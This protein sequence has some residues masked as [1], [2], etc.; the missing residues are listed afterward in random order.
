MALHFETNRL[1]L[2]QFCNKDTLALENV[3][4]DAEVMR[5]GAGVQ[6]VDWISRWIVKQQQ[7]YN[8]MPGL[9]LMAVVENSSGI[10]CG[11][12]GLTHFPDI[13]GQPEI[14]VGY[15]LAQQYWRQGYATEAALEVCNYAFK[16]LNIS[17]L[18][19]LIDPENFASIRVAEKLGMKYWKEVVLEGYTHPDAV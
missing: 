3:F 15:R 1:I 17:R 6:T 10:V 4:G 9:G 14:E 16:L 2:R 18:I 7:I 19:A 11:Y 5:F 13:D 12:C 8:Q